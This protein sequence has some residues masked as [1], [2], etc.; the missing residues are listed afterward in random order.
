MEREIYLDVQFNGSTIDD[1]KRN[2]T[3]EIY[4]DD[5]DDDIEWDACWEKKE[6]FFC[7]RVHVQVFRTDEL[8]R[9]N[10]KVDRL[11]S[12]SLL[13]L[14]RSTLRTRARWHR[15]LSMLMMRL[16]RRWTLK[17]KAK[18]ESQKQNIIKEKDYVVDVEQHRRVVHRSVTGGKFSLVR[19]APISDENRLLVLSY[20]K[21]EWRVGSCLYLLGSDCLRCTL[22]SSMFHENCLSNRC[23]PTRNGGWEKKIDRSSWLPK[24]KTFHEHYSHVLFVSLIAY[25]KHACTLL[26]MS[27]ASCQ[28][29]VDQNRWGWR[30][31]ETGHRG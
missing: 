15:R 8:E 6:Q 19:S 22:T 13:I 18:T 4:D 5:G 7:R 3:T 14:Q 24:Y 29:L 23:S 10:E 31:R 12:F 20:L 25:V 30:R 17:N 2:I 26:P 27:F 1:E 21:S 16:P 28:S 11:A 9:Q